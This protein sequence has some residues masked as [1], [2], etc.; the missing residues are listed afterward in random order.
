MKIGIVGAG[1][2]GIFAALELVDE[3]EVTV[4]EQKAYIGGSGLHSDGKLNFNPSIGGNLTDFVTPEVAD[5]IMKKIKG[6]FKELGVDIKESNFSQIER[7]AVSAGLK[8]IDGEQAHIGSDYLPSLMETLRERAES[9]G[10]RFMLSEPITDMSVEPKLALVGKD[11]YFFDKVIFAPGRNGNKGLANSLSKFGVKATWNPIDVGI[12]V[13]TLAKV[14]EPV[15]NECWDAKI[16]IYTSQYDD[17]VRTFCVCPYGFVVKEDYGNGLF[18]INGH[19]LRDQR[20]KNTNFALLVRINLTQPLEN[21]NIYGSHIVQLTN[22]LGGGNPIIQR[23]GDIR[24]CRRTTFSRLEKSSVVPTLD[25]FTPGDI[26]MAYPKRVM[27]DILESIDKLNVVAPGL[28]SDST[29]LYAPE[30]KFYSLKIETDKF[31]RTSIPNVSVAGDGAGVSR[32]IVGA[33]ATG[34]VA[35]MG[36]KDKV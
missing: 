34:V 21:T 33:A 32:G 20:S 2:A 18:G 22:T 31:L 4:F 15:T 35:A 3:N 29:L 28:N 26:A 10:V 7:S 30:V 36:L 12:R 9:K 6:L 1:P 19:S 27:E 25:K 13:E 5:R 23:L 16:H 14:M 17:F 8:F 24:H 11:V